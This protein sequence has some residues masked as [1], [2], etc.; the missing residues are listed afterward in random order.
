MIPGTQSITRAC[1]ILKLFTSKN[2]EM[3]LSEI[4]QLSGLHTATTYRVLQALTLEGFLIQDSGTG[5]Y[6]LGLGL[7]RLGE[8]SKLGNDL[9]RI[10][11]PWAEKLASQWNETVILD[12][13]TPQ[14]QVIRVLVFASSFRISSNPDFQKFVPPHTFAAGKVLLAYLPESEIYKYISSGLEKFTKNTI[15]D[16]EALWGELKKVKKQGYATNIGEQEDGF[17][18]VSAPVR[19]VY[20]EVCSAISLGGPD[21]RL[22]ESTIEPILDSVINTCKLISRDLGYSDEVTNE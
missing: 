8:L 12:V 21:S 15:V 22:N 19:N 13:M 6:R 11:H 4:A 3:T 16:P 10:S 5:K 20:G 17:N 18:A 14:F 7:L 1:S 9:Y 2:V